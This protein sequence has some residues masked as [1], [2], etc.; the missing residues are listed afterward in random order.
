MMQILAAKVRMARFYWS[1]LRSVCPGWAMLQVD[2]GSFALVAGPVAFARSTPIPPTV[3]WSE[4]PAVAPPVAVQ[5]EEL[6]GPFG[7][8]GN[9]QGT[10]TPGAP[11][12]NERP[13]SI[14]AVSAA[15]P[16]I[17]S[18]PSP[19]DNFTV[20]WWEHWMIPPTTTTLGIAWASLD[21]ANADLA[22]AEGQLDR[23]VGHLDLA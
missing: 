5:G 9:G 21:S 20:P 15:A 8:W 7:G 4:T 1:T 10:M 2:E 6:G 23:A 22:A 17:S 11:G 14:P 16:A 12:A 19:L 13:T 18:R 3:S